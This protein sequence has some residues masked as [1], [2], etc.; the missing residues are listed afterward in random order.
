MLARTVV[1]T[2]GLTGEGPTAKLTYTVVDGT[3]FL[4]DC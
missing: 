4:E 3:W 2:E 1:L